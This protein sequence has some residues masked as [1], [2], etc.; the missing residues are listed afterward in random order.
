MGHAG[1]ME[2]RMQTDCRMQTTL[3]DRQGCLPFQAFFQFYRFISCIS[4]TVTLSRPL[5]N[6]ATR[7]S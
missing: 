2:T 5:P 3:V 1:R 4:L 6:S 7:E